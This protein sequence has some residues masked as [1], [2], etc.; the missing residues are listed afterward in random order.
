MNWDP[1]LLFSQATR[2]SGIVKEIEEARSAFLKNQISDAL[3]EGKNMWKE[4]RHLGLIPDELNSHF[5]GVSVSDVDSILESSGHEGF[6]FKPITIND[7]ILAISHFSCQARGEDEIPQ[8][9]ILQA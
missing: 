5:A 2:I 7:V 4:L 8:S 3:D 9:V 6:E 1:Q